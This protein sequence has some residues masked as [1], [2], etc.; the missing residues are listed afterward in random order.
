[1]SRLRNLTKSNKL[2][3]PVTILF[4]YA[5]ALGLLMYNMSTVKANIIDIKSD[6]D[7]YHNQ[8]LSNQLNQKRLLE[9][10]SNQNINDIKK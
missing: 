5:S 6:N 9:K 8:F 7:F 4:G 3:L 2:E 1:M 10:I